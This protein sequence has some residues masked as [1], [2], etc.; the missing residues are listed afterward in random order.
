MSRAVGA[1][2]SG[3]RGHRVKLCSNMRLLRELV[4]TFLTGC[5]R[6]FFRSPPSAFLLTSIRPPSPPLPL[7]GGGT[8]PRRCSSSATNRTFC[9]WPSHRT[10]STAALPSRPASAPCPCPPPIPPTSR[11]SLSGTPPSQPPPSPLFPSTP[12]PHGRVRWLR[13]RLVRT[14]AVR[15]GSSAHTGPRTHESLTSQECSLR[16]FG[17]VL[18][19]G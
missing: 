14:A 6:G 7:S 18:M 4:R 1:A 12:I 8:A 5:P 2:G 9:A 17:F 19:L 10:S 15:A 11:I 3:E 16:M 13:W